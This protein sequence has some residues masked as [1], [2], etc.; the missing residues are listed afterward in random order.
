MIIF[1]F[2]IFKIILIWALGQYNDKLLYI[3]FKF[4][5]KKYDT[6]I[7]IWHKH[8]KSGKA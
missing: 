5:I 7:H 4:L 2:Y 1:I 8:P 3:A 6:Y